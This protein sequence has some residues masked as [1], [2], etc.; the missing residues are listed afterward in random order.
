MQSAVA[1]AKTTETRMF[2]FVHLT[3]DEKDAVRAE[4]E[5]EYKRSGR[6]AFGDYD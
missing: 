6:E 4:M 1:T 2:R 5:A 3:E